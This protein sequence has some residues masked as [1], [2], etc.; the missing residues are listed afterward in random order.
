M[1]ILIHLISRDF[2]IKYHFM[3]V[4]FE[5]MKSSEHIFLSLRLIQ[6][7]YDKLYWNGGVRKHKHKQK[8]KVKCK[9]NLQIKRYCSQ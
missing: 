4:V 5:L 7:A 6:K 3:F 2:K 9:N 8:V 1:K